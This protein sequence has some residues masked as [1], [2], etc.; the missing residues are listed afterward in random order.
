MPARP[1]LFVAC[2]PSG[3]RIHPP[4]V[5]LFRKHC[6]AESTGIVERPKNQGP[7][8]LHLRARGIEYDSERRLDVLYKGQYVGENYADLIVGSGSDTVIVELKAT[9]KVLGAPEKRQ[10][11][12]YMELLGMEKGLLINF[13]Q[14]QG[15]KDE[16]MKPE[17]VQ[18]P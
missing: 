17:I 18:I 9:P 7:E 4:Y 8:Q 10:L 2:A 3:S 11:R 14:L 12:K 16:P 13:P 6:P 5:K 1:C 15:K